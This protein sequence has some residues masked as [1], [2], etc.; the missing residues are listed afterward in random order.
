MINDQLDLT[1]R[2]LLRDFTE[3]LGVEFAA[4]ADLMAA[5]QEAVAG[6]KR[7]PMH[8]RAERD[9][10]LIALVNSKLK[11]NKARF[12]EFLDTAAQ[13]RTF[14]NYHDKA[15]L[16]E[17]LDHSDKPRLERW[18]AEM[19]YDASLSALFRPITKE[20]SLS[21][22]R[23]L[24]N[25]G[26]VNRSD[27]RQ[28]DLSERQTEI[29]RS[30]FGSYVFEAFPA[31]A[32][33]S[34][35]NPD[36]RMAYHRNFYH[37]LLEFHTTAL[38]RDCAMIYLS[39]DEILLKELTP[40]QL[41]DALYTFI[42]TT[43][44]RLANHCYLAMRIKPFREGAED[45]QWRLF[46]DLV[47]YA[48]KHREV[49]LQTGYF[50]PK[51]V[52]AA[53]VA[54][55]PGLR[56]DKA[57]FDIA[58]EGL[59]FR[60]CFVLSP[61][62]AQDERGR[63]TTSEAVDIL[64]LFEKNARDERVIPCP[65]CRSLD[66][67]GNSYPALGVKSWECQNPICPDRSAFDRGNRYSLSAIIKQEA[68]KSEQDQI[69]EASLR[70]WKLD[71]VFGVNDDAIID[72]LV[73][74]FSLHGD[75]VI[76]VDG[77]SSIEERYG[78]R[79]VRETFDPKA[80]VS[81]IYGEFQESAFFKRFIINRPLAHRTAPV[82]VAHK[83]KG[84][85][86]YHGDCFE[87]LSGLESG[88]ADGAVTSPPYYNARSYTSWPNIYCYLYDMYNS[89]RAVFHALVPGG[90]Y[91][92]NIFDYFDNENS[93]A[94]SA[95]GKKRMILGPYVINLFRRVGFELQQNVA[96]YKG[97]IEGKR[98]FNQGNRSPYYQFPFNCWEHCLVFRK[99]DVATSAYVF[100]TILDAKP[101]FK[102]VR[103]ENVLGHT[104]PFPPAIPRLLI[105]QMKKGECVLD[106]F[107]GSMTTG[108][109]A[110]QN[111]LHSISIEMHRDYCDLGIRLLE[112]EDAE[113][114]DLL[115]QAS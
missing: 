48:E 77:S 26:K 115:L 55:V 53:T 99:P 30:L 70:R 92:F 64:V 46:S 36:A 15:E 67:R 71:V 37:H 23:E 58:N 10:R 93:V 94:L 12:Q 4:P 13:G 109:V 54:H 51:E 34:Y 72:M 76:V 97:E 22:L 3:T 88:C 110:H 83:V 59:F 98:N 1:I 47:L 57:R 35:F 91:V 96:W 108:R 111:G 66:V 89:A 25:T 85:V 56:P 8:E 90:V 32:M 42:A 102:T 75:S 45:G 78:R 16:A 103:G 5:G 112:Q 6:C 39:I 63:A 2:E 14:L 50:R 11:L 113:G 17:C 114:A 49:E 41:R 20:E 84:A 74:H 62:T 61:S 95:M 87:V 80:A 7:W 68:I 65:A 107:S 38:H 18:L 79:I 101:V 19:G 33:H 40:E 52:E 29:L 86:L 81:G 105:S 106:P 27:A 24:L 21:G 31:Q 44:D 82:K 60:D 73:R 69:P 43:Y 100:P 104:A 9:R 28:R